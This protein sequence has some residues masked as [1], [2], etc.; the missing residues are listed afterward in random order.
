MSRESK[1]NA[2]REERRT[3]GQVSAAD[4]SSSNERTSPGQFLREV[5]SELRKV[6]WPNRKEVASYTMVVLVVTL[7]LVAIVWGMDEV[8]RRAVINTLG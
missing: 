6:A 2:D 5:R 4:E 8:F 1:R 3:A 7:V